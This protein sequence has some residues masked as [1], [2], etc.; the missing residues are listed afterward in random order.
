M[1][2][3]PNGNY[4]SWISEDDADTYF[5]NRLHPSEWKSSNKEVALQTAFRDLNQLLNLDKKKRGQIFDFDIPSFIN[6]I[7][8]F[9]RSDPF[10]SLEICQTVF[11]TIVNLFTGPHMA[12]FQL[13]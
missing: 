1:I 2:V 7:C 11:D 6:I 8:Q 5:E 12:V 9:Q 13:F 10:F 3:Y 4:N